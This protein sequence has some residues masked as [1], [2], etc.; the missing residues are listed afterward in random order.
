MMGACSNVANT[1]LDWYTWTRDAALV[2]KML[3]DTFVQGDT[4]L[5][6]RI[7]DYI[8]AQAKL[9]GV[10][11]PSGDLSN[12]AGLAEPKFY[13]DLTRFD[14][15]WGRPQRDGPGKFSTSGIVLRH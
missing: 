4:S 6:P 2:F 7:R 8:S 10:S 9:Q 12:G 11:N 3:V 15:A 14:G 1:G 13:V 5:E